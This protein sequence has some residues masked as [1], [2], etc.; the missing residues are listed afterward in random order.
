MKYPLGYEDSGSGSWVPEQ[1]VYYVELLEAYPNKVL[2]VFTHFLII[3]NVFTH[4][5]IIKTVQALFCF[6]P[7]ERGSTWGFAS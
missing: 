7:S 2:N 5:L 1:R 4:F 6:F 3:I